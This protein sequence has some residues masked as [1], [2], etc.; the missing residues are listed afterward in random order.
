MMPPDAD[1]KNHLA[2]RRS[3]A[4]ARATYLAPCALAQPSKN[5]VLDSPKMREEIAAP[6]SGTPAR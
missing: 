5:D 1:L 3:L 2:N 4:E 6:R